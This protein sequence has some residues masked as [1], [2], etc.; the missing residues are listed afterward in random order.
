MHITRENVSIRLWGRLDDTKETWR[1][2]D[3]E[4]VAHRTEIANKKHVPYRAP[5]LPAKFSSVS[6][7]G[8]GAEAALLPGNEE[9]VPEV[10]DNSSLVSEVCASMGEAV[11]FVSEL[12]DDSSSVGNIYTR[13]VFKVS[14][15]FKLRRRSAAVA[16]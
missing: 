1:L 13:E 10:T 15:V 14:T 8:I 7:F 11:E 3:D 5:A 2:D 16:V 9:F 6:V 12:P 4:S